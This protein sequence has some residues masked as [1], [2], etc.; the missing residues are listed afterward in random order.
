MP[1]AGPASGSGTAGRAEPALGLSRLLRPQLGP[2]L[3]M[4]SPTFH[5]RALHPSLVPRGPFP[6]PT[7]PFSMRSGCLAPTFNLTLW[8]RV[9]VQYPRRHFQSASLDQSRRP[10]LGL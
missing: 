2:A 4:P 7:H 9:R 5:L 6:A 1:G 3:L 10:L 8:T